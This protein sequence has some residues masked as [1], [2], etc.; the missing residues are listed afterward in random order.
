MTGGMLD[1]VIKGK[2]WQGLTTAYN[3][4]PYRPESGEKVRSY[5]GSGFVHLDDRPN[6]DKRVMS[7]EM[8]EKQALLHVGAEEDG[9]FE[10]LGL[11]STSKSAGVTLDIASGHLRYKKKREG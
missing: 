6:E 11:Y 5:I 4:Y 10:R 2:C 9:V 7:L 8:F 1:F 3:D